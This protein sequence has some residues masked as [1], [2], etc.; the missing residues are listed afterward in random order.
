M[1]KNIKSLLQHVGNEI[2]YTNLVYNRINKKLQIDLKDNSIH[3]TNG[4][5]IGKDN[6][7]MLSR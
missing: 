4:V 7:R 3:H 2:C 5:R 6:K 1:E